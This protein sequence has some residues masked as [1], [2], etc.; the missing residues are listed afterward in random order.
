MNGIKKPRS[1]GIIDN[2]KGFFKVGNKFMD[3]KIYEEYGKKYA[4]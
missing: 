3:K 2:E 1:A 4:A